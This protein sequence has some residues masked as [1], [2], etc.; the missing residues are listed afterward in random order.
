MLV[1]VSVLAGWG[2][3]LA[4]ADRSIWTPALEPAP[5]VAGGQPRAAGMPE[6]LYVNFD[7]GVLH[8][9]CGNE[10]H[11]NCSTLANTFDGYVGPF[12]GNDT[13]RISIL[14]ATRKELAD[15]GVRVV[16][17]RPPDDVPY[18]MVMYGD[19]G[20]QDFAG[21]APYIDCEE[22]HPNDTSFTAAFDTSNTGSTVILQEAAHTWGLEHVDAEDDILNP[23]KAAGLHQ[24]F[25]DECYPIVANTALEPTPGS[26]NIVHTRFCET[27]FQNSWQE[28]RYLFGP[29]VPDTSAPTLDII[30][31]IDGETF[32]LPTTI[33]L[34]GDITDDLDPQFYRI[35]IFTLL[36]GEPLPDFPEQNKVALDLLLQEPP[37]GDYEMRVVI[38][39]EAGNSAE[40]TVT[41]TI[42]KEGSELPEDEPEVDDDDE[43]D[44]CRLGG[45]EPHALAL[46]VLAGLVRRRRTRS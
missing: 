43:S 41:F 39:D 17:Q 22:V 26:C 9:G 6:I 2:A 36:D 10:A 15:F 28:M 16:V 25:H 21:L 7:G 12:T 29:P 45:H 38:S 18:T 33:P 31:P 37:P 5:L 23:F 32:V 42:L 4:D 8:S 14:Q 11:Y 19:L 20:P 27:G 35:Q 44:G 13:Q 30:S 1:I 24:N 3:L 46:V 40:D 34:T